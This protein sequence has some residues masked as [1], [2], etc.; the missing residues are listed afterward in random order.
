[1]QMFRLL[2][3][4]RIGDIVKYSVI[5]SYPDG[6]HYHETRSSLDWVVADVELSFERG[7]PVASA[8]LITPIKEDGDK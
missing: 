4:L 7:I 1:M 3:R 5:T 2:V 8:V 6:S